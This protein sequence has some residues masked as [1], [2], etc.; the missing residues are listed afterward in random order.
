MLRHGAFRHVAAAAAAAR[1][2]CGH[3]LPRRVRLPQASSASALRARAPSSTAGPR[4]PPPPDCDDGPS[5]AT[6]Y[7]YF[8]STLPAGLPP[9]GPF[10]VDAAALR[11]EFLRLQAAA[12]PD[13]QPPARKAAAEAASAAINH[14][15][16]TLADPL[17]RAQYLLSL[18]GVDVAADESLRLDISSADPAGGGGGGDAELLMLVLDAHELIEAAEAPHHLDTLRAENDDRIRTCV[19]ALARAFAADDVDA[20][21]REAVRLRYWVNIRN[22]ID[23]WEEGKPPVLQH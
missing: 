11:R 16:R 19:D 10:A 17:L 8:P 6:L 15:Y 14:A 9:A 18:R 4:H 21:K 23:E 3:S 5:P 13:K 22:A 2:V 1:V 7:A 20:A 12:H